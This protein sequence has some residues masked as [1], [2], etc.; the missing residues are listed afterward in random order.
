M[1][2]VLNLFDQQGMNGSIQS[3]DGA[4]FVVKVSGM[5]MTY[6]AIYSFIES[7][8][9][10]F[11]VKEYSCKLSSLEEVFNAHA[12]ETMY[13]ELNQRLNRRRSTMTSLTD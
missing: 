12:T 1:A 2:G 5:R 9:E 4:Y 6:G 3:F 13:M 11:Y 10:R 8:K 7:V